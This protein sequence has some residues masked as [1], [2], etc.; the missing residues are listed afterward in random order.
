MNIQPIIARAQREIL[1]DVR[2]GIVPARVRSFAALH[3]HVDANCYGDFCDREYPLAVVQAVQ[4]ALDG[5]LRSRGLTMKTTK[6]SRRRNATPRRATTSTARHRAARPRANAAKVPA[7]YRGAK[8]GDVAKRSTKDI[9]RWLDW[10]DRENGDYS[11]IT[12]RHD[13]LYALVVYFVFAE[14]ER[15]QTTAETEASVRTLLKVF[16]EPRR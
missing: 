7:W 3:D 2:A 1:R 9:V 6:T 5:W 12:T 15:Y 13:A 14:E 4:D 11:D 16:P 8:L 10:N